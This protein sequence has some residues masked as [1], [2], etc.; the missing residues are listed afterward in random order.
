MLSSTRKSLLLLFFL[1][2]FHVAPGD[3]VVGVLSKQIE[4]VIAMLATASVG[5]IWS[6]CSADFGLEGLVD[7]FG[8]IKPKVLFAADSHTY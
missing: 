1:R 3:C 8:Q 6:A 4:T 2:Q 7:R 5:A